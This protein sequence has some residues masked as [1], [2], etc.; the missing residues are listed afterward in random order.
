VVYLDTV[1]P[2]PEAAPIARCSGCR[3][4]A[5][6]SARRLCGACEVKRLLAAGQRVANP[7]L[8][9]DPGE[10]MLRGESV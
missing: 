9:I 6:L 1:R 8:A 7:D 2:D 4:T 3:F 10:T 5:P